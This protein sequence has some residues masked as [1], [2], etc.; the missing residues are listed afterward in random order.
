M[1]KRLQDVIVLTGN[2][3]RPFAQAVCDHMGVPLG[4][5]LVSSFS[6]GETRVE[7]NDNV[8][9]RR[10]FIVQA[11]CP[12]VNDNLMELCGIL[13]ACRRASTQM[14][15]AVIPYFG[16]ARQDKKVQPRVPISARLVGDFIEHAGANKVIT[17]DLH[18]GQIQGFFY[19][20]VD[21]LWARPVVIKEIEERFAGQDIVIVSPDAG[22]VER[23]RSHAKRL[24]VPLAIVDKR[25]LK[26]NEVAEMNIIG[27]VDGMV[28]VILDDMADTAGTLTECSR[29][30][31]NHGA[32]SVHAYTVHGVLSGPAIDRINDSAIESFTVTD[33]IP[34]GDKQERCPK[35]RVLSVA[36]I[37][38][39]AMKRA[40][41][42]ES[43]SDLFS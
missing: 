36:H 41:T 39:E 6:D 8:R 35:L 14:I 37:F 1:D 32:K 38:G 3:N 43:V 2:A 16:Y 17:M 19:I 27:S 23:A 26:P 22:G 9:R 10:V 31:L 29:V 24:N 11:T 42:G 33:T 30:L 21:N 15:T 28:A 4:D 5:A 13:D 34:L 18:A 20:P 12:P 25:R 40:V 7:I